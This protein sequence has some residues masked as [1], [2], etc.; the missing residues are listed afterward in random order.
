MTSNNKP[1]VWLDNSVSPKKVY[2][3]SSG[4]NYIYLNYVRQEAEHRLILRLVQGGGSNPLALT[5]DAAKGF[6]ATIEK[7]TV[8]TYTTSNVLLGSATLPMTD[9][10]FFS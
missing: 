5:L 2:V 1:Y 3:H 6:D 7:V 10:G 9:P 4:S 8:Q